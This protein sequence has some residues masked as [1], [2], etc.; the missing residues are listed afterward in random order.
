MRT[1]LPLLLTTFALHSNA[2][3]PKSEEECKKGLEYLD[4]TKVMLTAE[5]MPEYKGGMQE[6]YKLLTQNLKYPT[7]QKEFQGAVYVGFVIDTLGRVRNECII[8]RMDTNELTPVEVEAL[9]LVKQFQD[10]EPAQ[11]EGKK[12]PVKFILPIR[13]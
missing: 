7:H 5:K 11:H 13:F 6:Y 10:W 9:R 12:V 1:L 2:Q 4:N 8:R 3:S